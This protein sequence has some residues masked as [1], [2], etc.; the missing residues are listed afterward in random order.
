[1]LDGACNAIRCF[2]VTNRTLPHTHRYRG[3]NLFDCP[4]SRPVHSGFRQY[5]YILTI[6]GYEP[7]AYHSRPPLARFCPTVL[8]RVRRV[9]SADFRVLCQSRRLRSAS[10]NAVLG[11]AFQG[12]TP[13]FHLSEYQL[14]KTLFS[15]S[16]LPPLRLT[17]N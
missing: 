12:V 4:T 11:E 10:S 3:N 1:M 9:C 8:R 13:S 6:C 17:P 16:L 2:L 7:P 14:G 5:F 15:P